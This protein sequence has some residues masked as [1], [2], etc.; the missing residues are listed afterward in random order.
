MAVWIALSGFLVIVAA[1][2]VYAGMAA[3]GGD[4]GLDGGA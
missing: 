2:C 1:L 3:G 4:P